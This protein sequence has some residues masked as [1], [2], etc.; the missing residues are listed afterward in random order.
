MVKLIK[1]SPEQALTLAVELH[2]VAVDRVSPNHP[3]LDS[4]ADLAIRHVMNAVSATIKRREAERVVVR[5][6]HKLASIAR[7]AESVK[8][9]PEAVNATVEKSGSALS[10]ES[11]FRKLT[12][13]S[14]HGDRYVFCLAETTGCPDL[15]ASRHH[16]RLPH[17]PAADEADRARSLM[18]PEM[19]KNS[20]VLARNVHALDLGALVGVEI[21]TNRETPKLPARFASLF[22][23]TDRSKK[24]VFVSVRHRQIPIGVQHDLTVERDPMIE[25]RLVTRRELHVLPLR[26]FSIHSK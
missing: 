15:D 17:R 13:G 11:L 20:D 14:S 25:K 21:T 12:I 3:T 16:A 7:D 1:G 26:R 8:D 2:D 18:T 22:S 4:V 19:A 6:I 23:P 24:P 5:R 9:H 10:T